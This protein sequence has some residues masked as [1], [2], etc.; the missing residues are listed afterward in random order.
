MIC[1][2]GIWIAGV[3]LNGVDTGEV[4]W[5]FETDDDVYS[6]P[7]IGNN[8]LLMVLVMVIFIL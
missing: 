6:S 5:V 4:I 3:N 7:A 1:L 2:G 8:C